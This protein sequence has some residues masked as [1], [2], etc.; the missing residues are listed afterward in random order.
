MENGFL[1][2]P[3]K[4]GHNTGTRFT[5][6]ILNNILNISQYTIKRVNFVVGIFNQKVVEVVTCLFCGAIKLN[7][8]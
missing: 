1:E 7:F 4:Y 2:P 3:K 6:Q 8:A 5:P